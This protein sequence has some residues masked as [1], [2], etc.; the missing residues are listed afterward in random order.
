MK[1]DTK[2]VRLL[3]VCGALGLT[4]LAYQNCSQYE[5]TST[6]SKAEREVILE[7]PFEPHNPRTTIGGTSDA[8]DSFQPSFPYAADVGSDFVSRCTQARYDQ[9]KAEV[10]NMA[11]NDTTNTLIPVRFSISSGNIVD[12]TSYRAYLRSILRT[13]DDGVT[14]VYVGPANQHIYRDSQAGVFHYVADHT[15][16]RARY[17]NGDR[18]FFDVI[19]VVGGYN[20]ELRLNGTYDHTWAILNYGNIYTDTNSDSYELSPRLFNKIEQQSTPQI[21]PLYVADIR[22]QYLSFTNDSYTILNPDF[23]SSAVRSKEYAVQ[24]RELFFLDRMFKNRDK[25][26]SDLST[27]Q[28]LGGKNY[29]GYEG[30]PQL[31]DNIIFG[32]NATILSMQYTPI[33]ID[34][35]EKHIRTSSLDW[36]SFFNLANLPVPPNNKGYKRISHQVAWLGGSLKQVNEDGSTVWKRVADDGFL[37]LPD[38]NNEVHSAEQLFSNRTI[39]NDRRYNNGFDALAAYA[40]K[41]CLSEVTEEKY[42]GPWD[43]AYNTLKVWVD[44]NRNGHADAGEISSLKD[45]G[46]AA[47]NP[48]S[49]N[50]ETAVDQYGNRTSI[51]SSVLIA[52]DLTSGSMDQSEI[53]DRLFSGKT[54]SGADADFRV[55]IDIYFRSRPSFFLENINVTGGSEDINNY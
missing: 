55:M 48:C 27:P 39:I 49:F 50:H 42:I 11:S 8:G 15:E 44:A 12:E 7:V 20:R 43:E 38:S 22:E 1:L 23:T 6:V 25:F 53:K 21:I 28:S 34:L 16:A 45:H 37:V 47:L 2:V 36:G 32:Y 14:D 29:S 31:F 52:S 26:V 40:N 17:I 4:L 46:I 5:M 9:E 54:T 3:S 13:N 35:G 30:M 10:L 18:C 24:L 51:R 19:R 33:V 41:N